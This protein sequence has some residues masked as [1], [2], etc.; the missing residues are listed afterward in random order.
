MLKKMPISSTNMAGSVIAIGYEVLS[1]E[2]A[3]KQKNATEATARFK[4]AVT[5]EDGLTYTEP[6]DWPVPTRQLQG[7]ALLELGRAR[8]AEIAF[9]DDMKK[10]P[11]NGWSLMGLQKSLER[12]SK[13]SEA[14]EVKTRLDK[15]WPA[16]EARQ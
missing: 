10:F 5:L 3:V 13:T 14:A 9:R 1:G 2:I 6:P 4:Q 8:D 7:A 15:A 12:Q 11:D 16:A